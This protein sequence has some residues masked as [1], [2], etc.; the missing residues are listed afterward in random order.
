[1]DDVEVND[2]C[3]TACAVKCFNPHK[4]DVINK[5]Y[6]LGFQR[7]C[8]SSCG[9]EFK[10][11]K[12]TPAQKAQAEKNYKQLVKDVNELDKF[13]NELEN[14]VVKIV[15]PAVERYAKKVEDLCADY[16]ETLKK[17]AKIDLGCDSRCV[18]TCAKQK[19][20]NFWELPECI[21]ECQCTKVD[22]I[23]LDAKKA[24]Y[25]YPDLALYAGDNVEGW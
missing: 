6:V 20:F 7:Q 5:D 16:T 21:S 1:M 22:K 2:K 10:F 9:C 8:F 24:K 17:A 15:R 4:F 23:I 19:Y 11:E 12:W 14:D 25:S 13:H 3:N 18:D